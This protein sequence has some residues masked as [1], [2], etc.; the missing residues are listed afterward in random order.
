M[1]DES[2]TAIVLR[3]GTCCANGAALVKDGTKGGRVRNMGISSWA[4][5]S[6][7]E[8][9]PHIQIQG[10]SLSLIGKYRGTPQSTSLGAVQDGAAPLT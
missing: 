6:V 10:P 9:D 1:V 5:G 4:N 3:Y 2:D 7:A 8:T